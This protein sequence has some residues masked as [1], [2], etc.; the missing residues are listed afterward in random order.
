MY[1]SMYMYV[2]AAEGCECECIKQ[3]QGFMILWTQRP[4]VVGILSSKMSRLMEMTYIFPCAMD[5]QSL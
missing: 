5:M 2:R 4:M 1:M 3:K